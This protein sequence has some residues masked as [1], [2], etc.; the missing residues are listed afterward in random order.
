MANTQGFEIVAELTEASLKN[1]FTAAWD[2]GGT[3]GTPNSIP[4]AFDIPAG[5]AFGPYTLADGH[6][7]IPRE[8]LDLHMAPDVNGV[9]LKFG[10]HIDVQVQNPPVPSAGMFTLTADA[11][12]KVPVAP[13]AGGINVGIVLAGLPRANVA[14]H[15]TSGDPITP[16][17]GDFIADYVH[18]LYAANGTT[19]PHTISQTG[20]SFTAYTVDAFAELF[21]DASD[22]LRHIEVSLAGAQVIIK[23][24]LHLRIYNIHKTFA[25]AP[26]LM[27]PMGVE[28]KLVIV[29]NLT[30]AAGSVSVDLAG[31]AL[32]TEGIVRAPH[33][34]SPIPDYGQEGADY[35]YNKTQLSTFGVNL[36][37]VISA[38]IVQQGHTLLGAMA[39][40]AFSFPTVGQIETAIGDAFHQQLLNQGSLS[41]WT[42]QTGGASP[43]QVTDVTV[44]A[45]ASA[46]AIALNAGPGANAGALDDFV[47]AG[48]S[49]AI[50]LSAAQVL[51]IIEQ[52]IHLPEAQGGFGPTFPNPPHRFHDVDGHDVDLKRL[53]PSLTSALHFSGDVTVI[54][55]ILGSI[56]V[57][58]GFD[59]DVGLHWADNPSGG[60]TLAADTGKPD[61]HLSGL[62]WLLSILIGFITF[63][64]LGVVIAVV[65]L[66][67]IQN[68][69]T[70]VGGDV[71]RSGVGNAV[72]GISAWPSQLQ[73]IGT[74][75]SRFQNPVGISPDGL[76]FGG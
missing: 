4:H 57:D 56:D 61:V 70:R 65:V 72:S 15:L 28:A 52:T 41:V 14:A 24:P 59:V 74:V 9:D 1:F 18:Q 30:T 45:L 33:G 36:D 22:P 75:T 25:L 12:A 43:V 69:A 31:A 23:I 66:E 48:E 64:V 53:D 46:L 3:P 38:Q 55:A 51:A 73:G 67:V 10:L 63:G 26:N 68:I 60:Q 49:F 50:A 21:D 27:D 7:Q 42:P 6:V 13:L 17:L 39:P 32:S 35:A 19:F 16:H 11:D 47:P 2:S 8:E 40:I 76:L 58:A 37:D 62:T 34:P 5:F 29:A 44:Q 54:N 20:Q 71:V